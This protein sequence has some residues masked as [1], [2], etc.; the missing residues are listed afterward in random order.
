MVGCEG[1]GAR[2]SKE[3]EEKH[4]NKPIQPIIIICKIVE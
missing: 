3:K 1:K 2:V 4:A